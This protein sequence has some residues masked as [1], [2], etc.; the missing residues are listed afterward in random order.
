[1]ARTAQ[2]LVT[3]GAQLRTQSS[4]SLD[5]VG[6]Q[7]FTR[8][9]N[10]RRSRDQL[11][12][13]EGWTT[14]VPKAGTA[15]PQYTFDATETPT[16]YAELVRGD[17][18]KVIIGASP[19]KIKFFDVA[20][21]A[22]VTI[23]TVA[24]S[25]LP[26]QA[27]VLSNVAIFNRGVVGE[28]PY[29]W[30]IGDAAAVPLYEAREQGIASA[31][32]IDAY[33]GFLFLGDIVE[34]QSDQLN[35]F[36]AGYSAFTVASTSAKVA[37]FSIS[38]PADNRVQFNVT[39]GAA[40]I[41]ATLPTMV[42]NAAPFYVWIAKSDAG[43]GTVTTSPVVADEAVVLDSINDIALVW[44]NGARWVAR[45][46]P[47]GTIPSTTPFGIPPDEILQHIPD[48]QAWSELGEPKN[49]APLVGATMAAASTTIYIPFVPANWVAG[50]TRVAVVGGG[51]DGGTLGGQTANPEGVLITAIGAFSAAN[52]GYP[53]TIQTT[54]DTGNT[55]P[56]HV[57]VLRWEDVSAFTGKQRLGNGSRILAMFSLNG[58]QIIAHETGFF[59]NRFT[60]NVRAP[61]AIR[62]KYDGANVPMHGDSIAAYNS[63]LIIYPTKG[64]NFY[65]FD[66]ISDPLIHQRCDDAK[67]LFFSGL[68]DS[69][70]I[71]AVNNPLTQELWFCRPSLV[72][73]YCYEGDS[74]GVSEIDDQID[75]AIFA[76]KPDGAEKWF[77]LGIDNLVMV[78]GMTNGEATTW[79]RNA[80]ATTGKLTSGLMNMGTHSAEKIVLS[81]TP[82]LASPSPD[83]DF[84]VQVRKTYNANAP[85]TDCFATAESLPD[86]D[87]Q[88]LIPMFF[89]DAYWQDEIV[90]TETTDIDCRFVG[91]VWEFDMVGG[92]SGV[93]R[94]V[95]T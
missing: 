57:D 24:T 27:V 2:I 33:N 87:G 26:W 68:T 19:T 8:I 45:V 6:P 12:R 78:Y 20:T 25:A 66:G 10:F 30:E 74:V 72:M 37:S 40:A 84:T 34:I 67:D 43:A 32:R 4:I 15:A 53:I 29:T 31:G 89:Q 51:P 13:R 7:N 69:S 81:Y 47:S 21:A 60:A 54:T 17:G 88:N 56:L 38:A 70:R 92:Q 11:V 35:A 94:S 52:M 58:Q 36:M 95:S 63:E 41:V 16:R 9:L 85:L 64:R 50:Q 39:T 79:F 46:F 28:L 42:A 80:V 62:E 3:Q 86:P 73:A 55:Y 75:A 14:F 61:M 90:I 18:T 22:W 76:T 1:V 44:W 49:W 48:E 77:V 83:V 82:L 91:R 71:W 65:S 23:A 5:S 93:T 59:V